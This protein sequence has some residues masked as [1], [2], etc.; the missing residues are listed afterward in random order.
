M[1]FFPTNPPNSVDFILQVLSV[2]RARM[3]PDGGFGIVVR[4]IDIGKVV[5]MQAVL[6]A[7]VPFSGSQPDVKWNADIRFWIYMFNNNDTT[8]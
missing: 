2:Y 5:L 7:A 6:S 8:L 3:R 4:E 1:R